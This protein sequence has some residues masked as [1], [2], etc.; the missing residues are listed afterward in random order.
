[1]TAVAVAL[2]VLLSACSRQPPPA[3]TTTVLPG[4]TW[5]AIEKLPD[6]SGGWTQPADNQLGRALFEDC[7]IPGKGRAPFTPKYQKLRDAM[8]QRVD[9]GESGKDNLIQCLPDG[10]PGILLHGLVFQFL[11]TPGSITMLI[12]NGEVR[13]IY[14]D[15]RPHPPTDQWYNSV[16][17]HSVGR[18]EGN[19]LVV[20]TV[21]MR[22]DA[23][24]FYTG[25][26]AVTRNTHLT[27]RMWLAGKDTLMI[28]TTVQDPDIF[29]APY[30]Y[31]INFVRG[32]RE[33]DFTVGCSQDN[34][35]T[36]GRIDLTPP[37]D[38]P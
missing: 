1:M 36:E 10:M 8:A 24:L 22:T 31:K 14:T 37:P 35:D 11:F 5:A 16:E 33:S 12:E 29:A 15:G 20:D 9:R 27:E 18:W 28:E 6:F 3:V 2:A 23:M 32:L 7:C 25:G 30:V 4:S 21:G 19:T 17:G 26:M 38:E 13:R 34:R